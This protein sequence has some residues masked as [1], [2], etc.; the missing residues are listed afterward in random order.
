MFAVHT[1]ERVVYWYSI[2][3]SLHLRVSASQRPR[4]A[5]FAGP[6]ISVKRDLDRPRIAMFAG[7]YGVYAARALIYAHAR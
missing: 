7:R 1:G 6:S 5:M 4:I 2:Q 3:Y